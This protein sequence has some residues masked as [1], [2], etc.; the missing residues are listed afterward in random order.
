MADKP[1]I[2]SAP[3]IRA[4]LSARK[5]QTRRVLRVPGWAVE[6]D[7][8]GNDGYTLWCLSRESGFILPA[9]P[10]YLP[11]DR[12]WVREAWRTMNGLDPLS[13]AQIAADCET[14]GYKRPWSPVQY[15]ADGARVNWIADPHTFGTDPGRYRHA[16]FM[17]RWASRLTLIVTD[18]RVQ[19][20]QEISE[21]DA[22]AEG[23]FLGRCECMP[24]Q[25]SGDAMNRMFQQTWCAVHGDE[26]S[27]LWNSLHGP[28]AW[29]ANPWVVALTFTVHRCNIDRTDAAHG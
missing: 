2:F 17:P 21:A 27:A 28:D 1:I 25:R 3:M 6:I 18:V 29:D 9:M 4:L 11:H 15:E 19:R 7:K 23:S 5:T 24:P 20:L 22:R 12:L 10:Q 13:G 26:F 8:I 14:A 16:R